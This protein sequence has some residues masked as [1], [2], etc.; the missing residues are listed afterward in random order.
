MLVKIL[1]THPRITCHG[2]LFRKRNVAMKGPLKVFK[3]I[4]KEFLSAA[5]RQKHPDS[6]IDQVFNLSSLESSSVGFKLMLGQHEKYRDKIIADGSFKKILLYRHN[7]LACYSSEL[8]AKLTGQGTVPI[9]GS[10]KSAKA[11][12]NIRQY[13]RFEKRRRLQYERV[14]NLIKRYSQPVLEVDYLSLVYGN[15][16]KA[17]VNFL[18]QDPVVFDIKP[19]TK[20]RNPSNIVDRFE[21][22]KE[23]ENFIVKNKLEDWRY[24][25]I[26]E[27]DKS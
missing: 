24:E 2:E 25:N 3:Q 18:G 22:I 17:V 21:N 11:K 1:D 7:T 8:I 19:K 12:F 14:K 23:V 15:G 20:K 16:I 6:L 10:V 13:R 4:D 27:I 26:L 9:S 5:Y